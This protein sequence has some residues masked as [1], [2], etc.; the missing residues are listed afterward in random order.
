M[1][2][3]RR[4]VNFE[5]MYIEYFKHEKM[6][7]FEYYGKYSR[8]ISN[9]ILLDSVRKSKFSFSCHLQIDKKINN[10]NEDP[11]KKTDSKFNFSQAT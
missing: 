9:K 1:V 5:E 2:K 4:N 3:R 8:S 7:D 10:V 11:R 6:M